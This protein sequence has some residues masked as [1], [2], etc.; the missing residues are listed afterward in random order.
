MFNIREYILASLAN[1]YCMKGYSIIDWAGHIKLVKL[2]VVPENIWQ[3]SLES[4]M[5]TFLIYIMR[6]KR[7]IIFYWSSQWEK[8]ICTVLSKKTL[9]IAKLLCLGWWPLCCGLW[10]ASHR[11]SNYS[12]ISCDFYLEQGVFAK[13]FGTLAEKF[14]EQILLNPMGVILWRGR[15]SKLPWVTISQLYF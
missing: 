4:H 6:Q 5:W 3:N 13:G 9:C 11:K 14:P 2:D 15:A 12:A 10:L 7:I 1:S 8:C